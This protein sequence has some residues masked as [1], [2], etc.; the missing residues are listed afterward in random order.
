[1]A[2]VRPGCNGDHGFWTDQCRLSHATA[3]P[4]GSGPGALALSGK[5]NFVNLTS[6]GGVGHD[7]S[8]ESH[9]PYLQVFCHLQDDPPLHAPPVMQD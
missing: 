7:N 6:A 3:D 1:M 5:R 9:V 8:G 4:G 2:L